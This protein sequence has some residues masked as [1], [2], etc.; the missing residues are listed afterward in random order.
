VNRQ[1][2]VRQRKREQRRGAEN[3][4]GTSVSASTSS[5]VWDTISQFHPYKNEI[6]SVV[7]ILNS[8]GANCNII[9]AALDLQGWR[10]FYGGCE[11][12]AEDV[13]GLLEG[14]RA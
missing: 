14:Y 1:N 3:R 5:K 2:R 6:L 8:I 7:K 4:S 10:T 9:S 11:W 13:K 12:A